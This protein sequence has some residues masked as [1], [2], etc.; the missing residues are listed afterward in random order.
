MVCAIGISRRVPLNILL[1]YL[2]SPAVAACDG[3]SLARCGLLGSVAHGSLRVAWRRIELLRRRK[4]AVRVGVL[5]LE[6]GHGRARLRD[7][8]GEWWNLH[9]GV[10]VSVITVNLA[11]GSE[12]WVDCH[13]E[14]ACGEER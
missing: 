10:H 4:R 12:L 9:F 7:C 3:G 8:L 11:G 5:R 2:P 13:G 1:T 6:S 14:V